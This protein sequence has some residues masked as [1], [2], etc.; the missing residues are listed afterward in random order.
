[1]DLA[2]EGNDKM[3]CHWSLHVIFAEHNGFYGPIS[4]YE[5]ILHRHAQFPNTHC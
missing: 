4:G 1:M 3:Y 5:G 2:R